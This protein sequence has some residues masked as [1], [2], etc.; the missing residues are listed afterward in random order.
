VLCC[1][2]LSLVFLSST[3]SRRRCKE[4]T[5][6]W[7][8]ADDGQPLDGAA[9]ILRIRSQTKVCFSSSLFLFLLVVVA[10]GSSIYLSSFCLSLSSSISDDL[11][12]LSPLFLLCRWDEDVVFKNQARDLDSKPKGQKRFINDTIRSD[13][14]KAFMAKYIK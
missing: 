1:S 6:R 8:S 4:S 12:L 5:R 13:F 9:R 10:D 2:F 14:H 11:L 3:A 7:R